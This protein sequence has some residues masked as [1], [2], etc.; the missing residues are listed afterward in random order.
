VK[1]SF[2][3][4]FKTAIAVFRARKSRVDNLIKQRISLQHNDIQSST[5]LNA[6]WSWSLATQ[7]NHKEMIVAPRGWRRRYFYAM[8]KQI[9]LRYSHTHETLTQRFNEN[10]ATDLVP[11]EMAS[12]LGGGSTNSLYYI[13]IQTSWYWIGKK[14]NRR[15]RCH[16]HQQRVMMLMHLNKNVGSCVWNVRTGFE[17]SRGCL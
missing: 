15:Q 11:L 4:L 16:Y 9:S 3:K 10:L 2:T 5:N 14:T 12:L 8:I 7:V 17:R 13:Y 6:K 1:R